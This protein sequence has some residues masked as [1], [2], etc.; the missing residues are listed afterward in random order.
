MIAS[1][2]LASPPSSLGCSPF[3]FSPLLKCFA[4]A[5]DPFDFGHIVC[6]EIDACLPC[7]QH[8]RCVRVPSLLTEQAS[9]GAL[10]PPPE[11]SLPGAQEL[12]RALHKAMLHEIQTPEQ[13]IVLMSCVSTCSFL[14]FSVRST[15]RA[16]DDSCLCSF[17]TSWR[18]SPLALSRDPVEFTRYKRAWHSC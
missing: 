9:S 16:K 17:S 5:R 13:K 1:F 7:S 4:I 3:D 15:D 14:Y 6:S 10:T 2:G 12:A 8:C 11:S 18:A